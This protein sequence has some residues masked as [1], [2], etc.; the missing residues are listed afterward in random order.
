VP[1][2]LHR[3]VS[4][5]P[6]THISFD[7]TVAGLAIGRMAVRTDSFACLPG[8]PAAALPGARVVADEEALRTEVRAAAAGHLEPVLSGFGPRTRRRGRAPWGMATDEIVEGL[9]Y[10]AQL[11]GEPERA[12]APRGHLRDLPAHLRH[13][14][15][16]QAEDR[17]RQLRHPQARARSGD[18]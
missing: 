11:L 17:R 14:P 16:G 10:V 18:R 9:W 6:V 2:F 12:T 3:P 7:R 4:R 8:D 13:G 5:F 1:W 15:D